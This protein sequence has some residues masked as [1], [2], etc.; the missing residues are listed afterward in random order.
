MHAYHHGV[1]SSKIIY[2]HG[3]SSIKYLPLSL[4]FLFLSF[5]LGR[6]DCVGIPYGP[7]PEVIYILGDMDEF[8]YNYCTYENISSALCLIDSQY[9]IKTSR[10]RLLFSGSGCRHNH[11]C[12]CATYFRSRKARYLKLGPLP[13]LH[14]GT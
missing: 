6:C 12:V 2:S 4:P 3:V 11:S 14:S 8:H 9:I 10:Q 5:C 13:N 7:K 1:S